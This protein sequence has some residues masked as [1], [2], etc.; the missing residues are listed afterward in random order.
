MDIFSICSNAVLITLG[1]VCVTLLTVIYLKFP[2]E[3]H[4]QNYY[5]FDTTGGVQVTTEKQLLQMD[6]DSLIDRSVYSNE[7]GKITL[8]LDGIYQISY[9]AQFQTSTNIGGQVATYSAQIEKNEILIQ[10]SE[11]SCF[12]QKQ[13]NS[14]ISCG[15]SKTVIID[16]KANDIVCVKFSRQ[17]GTTSGTTKNGESSIAI[18]KIG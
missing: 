6:K 13:S 4:N 10:G 12:I 15:C 11:S 7:N 8:I 3:Y 9:T 16:C 1:L 17:N 14:S 2:V 18:Q 5:G